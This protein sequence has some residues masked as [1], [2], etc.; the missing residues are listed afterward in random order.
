MLLS[1]TNT[2]HFSS[3]QRID[4]PFVINVNHCRANN[5][6]EKTEESRQLRLL[7]V[8]L[9][10]KLCIQRPVHPVHRHHLLTVIQLHH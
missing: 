6:L 4:D 1:D 10:I 2:F 9:H 5:F 3:T 8:L 7:M